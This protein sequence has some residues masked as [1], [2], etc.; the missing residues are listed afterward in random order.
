MCVAGSSPFA[1]EFADLVCT[2]SKKYHHHGRGSDAV[3]T[4][5]D[6]RALKKARKEGKLAEAM[7]DRRAKLKRCVGRNV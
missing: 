1:R 3:G 6:K 2:C 4:E 5:E 7:L